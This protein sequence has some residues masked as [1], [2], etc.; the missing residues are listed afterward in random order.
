[1]PTEGRPVRGCGWTMSESLESCISSELIMR[2]WKQARPYYSGKPKSRRSLAGS[3]VV[4]TAQ[5]PHFG[6][7]PVAA[8]P[9]KSRGRAIFC[10]H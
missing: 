4:A 2:R 7:A 1:M 9:F 6:T 5:S 10:G 8:R 3:L